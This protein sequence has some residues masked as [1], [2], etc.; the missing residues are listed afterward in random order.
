MES[1]S[2]YNNVTIVDCNNKVFCITVFATRSRS[3][4]VLYYKVFHR[5]KTI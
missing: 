3:M 2:H 4:A 5:L 1:R